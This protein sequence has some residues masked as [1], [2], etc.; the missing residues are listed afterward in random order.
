MKEDKYS[1]DYEKALMLLEK[2]IAEKHHTFNDTGIITLNLEPYPGNND[3]VAYVDPVEQSV[4]VVMNNKVWGHGHI[5]ED[6]T[7]VNC[8]MRKFK[9]KNWR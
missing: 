3:F 2:G 6:N 7:V 9:I 5:A 8:G 1:V 4:E